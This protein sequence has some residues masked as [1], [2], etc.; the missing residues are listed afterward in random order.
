[1]RALGP[2]W[3]IHTTD[4]SNMHFAARWQMRSAAV[5][6][7]RAIRCC[8]KVIWTKTNYM[9][10]KPTVETKQDECRIHLPW[11]YAQARHSKPLQTTWYQI[12]QKQ[13]EYISSCSTGY[14]SSWYIPMRLER[15]LPN[16]T[17]KITSIKMVHGSLVVIKSQTHGQSSATCQM[18]EHDCFPN[19]AHPS[20]MLISTLNC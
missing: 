14:I 17:S 13:W 19:F 4:H 9:K 6:D 11:V 10:E 15:I 5:A 20:F 7:R 16:N 2:P 8:C 18:Y 12:K 1:M 3:Y